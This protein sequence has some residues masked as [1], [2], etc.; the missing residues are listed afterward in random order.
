[1]RGKIVD[2]LARAD[3]PTR[4]RVRSIVERQAALATDNAIDSLKRN[5]GAN[6]LGG[7]HP[8]IFKNPL[9][10]KRISLKV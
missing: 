4:L 3:A 1:M 5:A 2:L 7:A 9:Q 8:E 6:Q 10:P